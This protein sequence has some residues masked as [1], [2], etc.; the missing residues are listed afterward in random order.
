LKW[1]PT[2]KNRGPISD[3]KVERL[4][5]EKTFIIIFVKEKS[6]KFEE[7]K[8]CIRYKSVILIKILK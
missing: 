1:A 8:K 3:V 4:F 6:L 7:I 2:N 5:F